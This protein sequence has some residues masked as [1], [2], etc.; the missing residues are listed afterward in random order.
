MM[1]HQLRL[2]SGTVGQQS[3]DS[4]LVALGLSAV[5]LTEPRQD[6]EGQQP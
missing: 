1:K 3:I 4:T 5:A 2:D 6:E